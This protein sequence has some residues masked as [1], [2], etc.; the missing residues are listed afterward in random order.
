MS[1]STSRAPH[2]DLA[3][4]LRNPE[5]RRVW[6]AGILTSMMRWLDL[7]V[8]GVF[9]FDLTDSA[10]QVALVFLARMLPRLLFGV[11][12]GTMADRFNRKHLWVISLV[13][14]S[15]VSLALG[16]LVA[17]GDIAYW[18]VLVTVFIA[19]I[20]WTTEF[21]VRRALM[22]DLVPHEAIGR[23][24]SVDWTTDSFNRMVGPALGGGL[25]VTV[26]ADGAYLLIAAV[27]GLAALVATTLRY[28]PLKRDA[29][30]ESNP[31]AHLVG[32][33][34]YVR[35]SR[36]LVGVLMVTILFNLVFSPYQSMIPV[37]G[38]DVLGADALRV[39]LL[40]ATEG[41]GAVFGALWIANRARPE[42][43]PRIYY[44]GTGLFLVSALAF[45]QSETYA[46]SSFLLF[47]AGFGFSAFAVMQTTILVRATS[48]AMRGRVLGVL[49]LAIGAGPVGALQVGPLVAG[50]GEQT[51][52]TVLVLEG[53]VGLVFV[54]ALWP[55][56]RRAWLDPLADV[57]G[58][59][60][61]PA[62]D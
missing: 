52:L 22:A 27:F 3:F 34:R 15:G 1:E 61:E 35:A 60:P 57:A 42:G 36:L 47:S 62:L 54:G 50:L 29:D 40:S 48:P 53:L 24:V 13:G 28:E 56:L 25:L 46:L 5:F 31:L 18:H 8:L 20:F 14:L 51:T 58:A 26:G 23:A 59:N 39:G 6:A 4:V 19:G 10:G 55:M 30:A 41:L 11:L 44:Y 37:I 32:G 43:Y 12:L 16:L 9:T 38:K 7:L 33:L 45:S 49:S 21:P 17:A 2:A